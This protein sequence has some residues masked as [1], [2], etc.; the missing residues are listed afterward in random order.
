MESFRNEIITTQQVRADLFKWKLIISAALASVGLGINISKPEISSNHLYLCLIPLV[1]TYVDVFCYHLDLRALVISKFFQS[2]DI[3]ENYESEN[4]IDIQLFEIDFLRSYECFCEETRSILE[5]D[6]FVS[7]DTSILLSSL[8]IILAIIF[9]VYAPV[10]LN[11]QWCDVILILFSLAGI[12]LA[13]F[14][15][16]RYSK[17]L[18]NLKKIN[19]QEKFKYHKIKCN[20]QKLNET[21]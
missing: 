19:F 6:A 15:K 12:F 16:Y 5:L 10:E 17:K 8:L 7:K 2:I 14:S 21:P 4:D 20:G 9:Y 18:D 1:C 13:C 11:E 3:E